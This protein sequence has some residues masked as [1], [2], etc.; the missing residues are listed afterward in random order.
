MLTMVLS[1]VVLLISAGS[2]GVQL[3]VYLAN[4]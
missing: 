4:Q 2:F 1:V 3:M